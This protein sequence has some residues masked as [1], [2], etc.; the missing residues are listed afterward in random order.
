MNGLQQAE[1]YGLN[2]VADY[3]CAAGR[4]ES[5]LVNVLAMSQSQTLGEL[6]KPLRGFTP[7][8][9]LRLLEEAARD[10]ALTCSN[11]DLEKN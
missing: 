11:P 1:R 4:E 6:C 9:V 2:P 10:L 5:L 7:E 3:R 8:D